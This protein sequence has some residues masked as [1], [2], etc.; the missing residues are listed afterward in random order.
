MRNCQAE[1]LSCKTEDSSSRVGEKDWRLAK[2]A[3]VKW[4]AEDYSASKVLTQNR[5]QKFGKVEEAKNKITAELVKE[6]NVRDA[7]CM[8]LRAARAHRAKEKKLSA[9]AARKYYNERLQGRRAPLTAPL[10]DLNLNQRVHHYAKYHKCPH[11]L[12]NNRIQKNGQCYVINCDHDKCDVNNSA[13]AVQCGSCGTSMTTKYTNR[14]CHCSF[15]SCRRCMRAQ[16]IYEFEDRSLRMCYDKHNTQRTQVRMTLGNT[17]V[18][19]SFDSILLPKPSKEQK[20]SRV[21]FLEDISTPAATSFAASVTRLPKTKPIATPIPKSKPKN[22]KTHQS[23]LSKPVPERESKFVPLTDLLWKD[24]VETTPQGSALSSAAHPFVAAGHAI[25]EKYTEMRN[26][27]LD[28]IQ[29]LETRIGANIVKGALQTLI[30]EVCS[31]LR[32]FVGLLYDYCYVLNPVFLF[33][34]WDNRKSPA[35][36]L[37][38]LAEAIIHLKEYEKQNREHALA[39]LALGKETFWAHYQDGGHGVLRTILKHKFSKLKNPSKADF[40]NIIKNAGITRVFEFEDKSDR[41]VRAGVTV[42]GGIKRTWKGIG[43]EVETHVITHEQSGLGTIMDAITNLLS[44]FPKSFGNG[45]AFLRIFFKENMPILMGIRALGDL[46]KLASKLV[47]SGMQILFGH[48]ATAKEWIELQIC[49]KDNPIHSLT[50]TYMTYLALSSGYAK[51]TDANKEN[52]F[53]LRARF[54]VEL[55]AADAYVREKNK[56]GAAWLQYKRALADSFN[57]P[58]PPTTRT[59]EPLCVVLSG[60]AG[61]GKSTLWKV[62]LSRELVPDEKE[63]VAQKMEDISH[64]W[65]S[66]AEYQPGMSN[67]RIIVFDD[68]M[69]NIGEVDEALNVIALCTTAPYPVTVATIS[70]PE[71]KGMFCEPDAVVLCT[72]TVPSRAGGQL[73]D[74]KALERRYDVDFEIKAKYDPQDPG[75]HIFQIKR[76][77]MFQSLVEKTVDL[78]MARNITSVLYKKKRAEF[79]A[80]AGMVEALLTTDADPVFNMGRESMPELKEAW[81]QNGDFLAAY[82]Q[83]VLEPLK[84]PTTM[85]MQNVGKKSETVEKAESATPLLEEWSSGEDS[86]DEETQTQPT[87]S[88]KKVNWISNLKAFAKKPGKTEK[89][90][91]ENV[92]TQQQSSFTQYSTEALQLMYSSCLAGVFTGAPLAVV[93]SFAGFIRQLSLC[94]YG[95]VTSAIRGEGGYFHYLRRIFNS[96]L[97]CA[98]ATLISGLALFAAFKLVSRSS[99]AESGVTRTAKANK[100]QIRTYEE[101]GISEGQQRKLINATGSVMVINSGRTTNCVFVGGQYV[102]VPYHLFTD[103]RGNLLADGDKVEITKVTWKDLIKSFMFDRKSVVRLTGNIDEAL[104]RRGD[105]MPK[106]SYREDVCLYRLPATMFSAE[107]NIVK[108]FWDG[109]YCTTN[110]PVRKLDYIP[111]N[112][113]HT[114]N[115][116]IILQDGVIKM[117]SVST[118]R[119]EGVTQRY[120]VLAEATYAGRDASCGSLVVRSDLQETPILGIH[121]AAN[122]RGSYFHYVTRQSLTNA[123]SKNTVQDVETRFVHCEPQAAIAEIL[124]KQSILQAVGRIEKPLFQP[125]K[126]DLQPSVLYELMGPAKTAPAPL[127]HKDPRVNEEFGA[128][129]PF[130]QQMFKGYSRPFEPA[131][132]P[133]ELNHA[134]IS[135]MEDFKRI[136]SQSMVPT[137]KLDLMEC[138][139]G[140]THIPQNTRMPMNTSCGYPYVQERLKKP[141]LFEEKEGR[142]YPSA[143]IILDYEHAAK[144]L[145]QGI[146]PFLP[147]VLSLKDER[148]KHDKIATPRTRIFT[149]GSAVGYLICR[150]YFYSS[151]MQYYHA[152]LRDSFCCPSL[153]RASF[154]WHYLA[155]HMLEVG[156]R[157]FDFDFTHWDRSLSHQLL[158]YS[159]KLLLTGLSLPPQEEAAVIEMV[160]SPFIIWGSTVL[161]GE[162]MPSGILVTFL[163]NCVANEMMHRVSWRS[164]MTIEHPILLPMRYYREYTRG[165]RGGDDTWSTADSRVLPY[166]NG[167]TVAAFLRSRGMQVT[168]AD[169][170][171]DI[172]ESS[173]FFDLSFLKNSTKYERGA[174]LPVTELESLYESTYWV[175]LSPENNDIVKATQDNATCSLRSL[176]FHGEEVFDNFRNAALERETKLVLPTYEELSVIWDNFHCFPGS[177]TDFASREIQEDPFTL[178]SKEKPRVP[179]T[180]RAKYNMSPIQTIETFYQSGLA[181]TALDKEQLGTKEIET[182]S[183][184][185]DISSIGAETVDNQTIGAP[186]KNM[187]DA[188]GASIQD[189]QSRKSMPVKTGDRVIQSKNNRSEVYMNDINW[190]LNKLVQ[191]FTFVTDFTWAEADS[192]GDILL[193]LKAPKDFLVT[194]AQREPFDVTRFW[195]GTLLVKIVIK[196]SPF[197]AGGLV[198]GFSPFD[199]QPNIP[200]IIN[201]GGLIH[202][203]SQEESLEYVIPFRWPLGFIDASSDELG[204]FAILVNSA[205]RTGPDNP[206][207]INGAV[208]VSIMDSE[209]KLPEVIPAAL[210]QSYKFGGVVKTQP[211]SGVSSTSILCDINDSPS[212]MPLTTMC[213]GEG[214]LGRSSIAH[215]QDSPS[216]LMQLLKRWEMAGRLSIGV[217]KEQTAVVIFD[218][219]DIYI[220]A[221]RGFD[222]YFGLFRGSVNLRFS[223]EGTNKDFYGKISFNPVSANLKPQ[224]PANCGLQTFDHTSMGMVTIPWTQPF[225]TSPTVYAA[226]TKF[227]IL[228][229]LAVTIY[230]HSNQDDYVL[231]NVDISVG[232]DFHMGV[233]LGTPRSLAFPTMYERVPLTPSSVINELTEYD[234][235]YPITQQQSGMLQFIGRAIENTLPIVEKM[236]EMGLELDAHMIT[237]QNQLVQQR[238]RPFSIACDLPVLTERFTTV[239]HNGMT[240]PDK[241]CFGTSEP[242]TDIYNLLQNTKS[243]VDRVEWLA[244]H[245]AGTVIAEYLN[246]PTNPANLFGVHSEM[247]RM[248]NFWTG[249]RIIMLDVHATQMHRGQLLLS[250]STGLE[251]M[252]YQDAT[253]SYFSTL[254]LSEGRATVALHL[255]YLSPLPQHRVAYLGADSTEPQYAIGRLRIFVQNALRS[256]TTVASDV[257]IV[258]YEACASDFQLNVYGGTPW[259]TATEAL[260]PTQPDGIPQFQR[261]P[262]IRASLPKIIRPGYDNARDSRS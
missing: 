82:E 168:A 113:D 159:T 97:T 177:H 138:I 174:F 30:K 36:F 250:Y 147:Y 92:I 111:Y 169:K 46:A 128:F 104:A 95:I 228:D 180:E 134:Y 49:T 151:I 182:A 143:R 233:F 181:M 87:T 257:E 153:D 255:P 22:A 259:R 62:L 197:Y 89:A 211:Q 184:S 150:K 125:T 76:C 50:T 21:R 63:N 123:I 11:G 244:S 247:S 203:L 74:Y 85:L 229:Q 88:G 2:R 1:T 243:L 190:D 10:L 17:I 206:N 186:G 116:Q 3:P 160:C 179:A 227:P 99:G 175:R 223:M 167:T 26:K 170:S 213:A 238:R 108:H 148:L 101:A 81:K 16:Y 48:C 53:D 241:E 98:T 29:E 246:S 248:F 54:Y 208:Y 199:T 192:V 32:Y 220:A 176:Y 178:A 163:V 122:S 75:K 58:P 9:I 133:S 144:Q 187:T 59:R 183:V 68:F 33:R 235:T 231:L 80:T 110:F 224:N 14:E 15:Y 28:K 65:N 114:Y 137:K 249:G 136:K 185:E 198:I 19:P 64:T 71:I 130:W 73:A 258:V 56:F 236:S 225:F 172:P 12:A 31:T 234:A 242:E 96:F 61:L 39:T 24:L 156:D 78:E 193:S 91:A 93:V 149:C 188:V 140:L 171:Q 105:V 35:L 232:D 155:K 214:V 86:E 132:Q 25:K 51:V 84:K 245:E 94:T 109:S 70:G 37:L 145:E 126:T 154:D 34:L 173:N 195:K 55:T 217:K 207:T 72:N 196:S 142:L 221:F 8:S 41:I 152:E 162:I 69:Q 102:L 119:F 106:D 230:N 252:T 209:F 120:H 260:A 131:F 189:A 20:E 23:V 27:A 83:Y 161:R 158:Y 256:T 40:K 57:T 253:Q 127:T 5:Q 43:E 4:T 79:T 90:A 146:V 103:S 66:A 219:R 129:I 139:N 262:K 100:G 194:P 6:A 141:D 212:K 200:A 42:K 165:T 254:D 117:D 205:L 118:P 237:E 77:P 218:L 226:G 38:Y 67:K 191:K 44:A 261:K 52:L 135:M 239:N 215:F 240:L 202:K 222:R 45:V 124:P 216:D 112:L 121:T 204:T 210:Y 201:M 7:A 13:E 18:Q 47:D 166:Y 157:G 115:G 164:I 107:S 251:D 60:G